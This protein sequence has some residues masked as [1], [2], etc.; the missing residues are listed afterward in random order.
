MRRPAGIGAILALAWLP[1]LGHSGDTFNGEHVP[2]ADVVGFDFETGDLQGWMV[3]EGEFG[4]LVCEPRDVTNNHGKFLL[5]TL[6]QE[7]G[8]TDGMTGVVESPV[9]E[10]RAPEMTF[11][12]GGGSH[13][14]TYVALCT[15][16]GK[17]QMQ[18][19]GKSSVAMQELKWQAPALVGQKV[20]LRVVDRN[21]GG[22]GHVTFDDF[23]ARGVI[24]A[25]ATKKR[26]SGLLL[27][28]LPTAPLRAA[29]QDLAGTFG[30][31]YPRA[32]E[33]LQRLEK[34]EKA[35]SAERAKEIEQAKADL[36]GLQ[37]EALIANPLVSS[38]P[39][40]FVVR[41]QYRPD[42]HNSE[43][44]FQTSE[45][46]TGSFTGP[47]WLNTLDLKTGKVTTLVTVP[48]GIARD[49]DVHWDGNKIVFSMRHSREDDYHLY[50][51][52]ADGSGL[53]QLTFGGGI[54]D[55]DPFYLADDRIA[56]SSTR[57]PKYCMCNRHIMCNL[58]VMNADASNIHQIGKSTLHEAHGSLL[59]DGRILYDRWEYVD[60]N[61]G[62][63]Q[64]LWTCNPDGTAH[65]VYFGN[66]TPSPGGVID[67]RAIPGTELV[68]AV[69]GSCH[70]RPW[71]ALGIIDVRF[72]VDGRAPVVRTWPPKA[73]ELVR[74]PGTA[75][76]AWDTFMSVKPKYED[77]YP[78]NEKYFL[79]S[80][81]TGHG[82]QMGLCLLDIFGN[83]VQLYAD[84]NG[85]LGCYDP[86]PL[87]PRARVPVVPERRDYE[88]KDG[89]MY[90]YD[91]YQGTHMQGVKRGAVKFL[92]VIESPEKRYWTHPA[93]SG[94]G[95]HCPGMN[96]H[97]FE[98]KRI[99]GVVPVEDDG[100]AYFA[101]PSDKFI[102]F[103]LL[104]ENGMMIQSMRSGTMMQSGERSGCVGCHSNRVAAPAPKAMASKAMMRGA[105]QLTGWHGPAR[106]Y[107]YLAE[108]QPVFD[109]ACVRCHDFPTSA[110]VP[111]T[112][113]G[114]KLVLAG[115]KNGAFNQSY[116]EL[117]TKQQIKV[118]GGGPAEIQQA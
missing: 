26:F 5:T 92:R 56:F 39:L 48:N 10:L 110:S 99:L 83:E 38:S 107:N 32:E 3:V 22:W 60:R 13:P 30:A 86:M 40:V 112:D 6:Q 28:K 101:V 12:V 116:T 43:T 73:V 102:Y 81:M 67:A 96:W 46:N 17:E 94:Q 23:A 69:L 45:I 1:L 37:R 75:N 55:I 27:A 36:A 57:E 61:F 51:I 109:R 44:M 53:K 52:N 8:K 29:I 89:Y 71:G 42:H 78:L 80:R 19:R 64:G 25:A 76:G 18:A 54:T 90:V 72:G 59:P 82:E 9:F 115:D 15:L 93:W 97:S 104:D 88:N 63:A 113:G 41:P 20:F 87:G 58:F 70:D 66:N 98:N 16:D 33:F 100:S 114:K 108:M 21:T 2:G 62:D 47:G 77:P 85:G 117:W 91:V 34:I 31:R 105:S 24:D 84:P 11:R 95:V 103:Q 79:A 111:P 106:E 49:P 4:K 35:L 14:D 118:V 65:L 7:K 74:E 68:M 50:E